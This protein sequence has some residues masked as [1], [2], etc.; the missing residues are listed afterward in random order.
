MVRVWVKVRVKVG[1]GLIRVQRTPEHRA[2]PC[3]SSR[4]SLPRAARRRRPHS[5]PGRHHHRRLAHR[6]KPC[7][8]RCLCAPPA[9]W[10]GAAES[11]DALTTSMERTAARL[12][13]AAWQGWLLPVSPWHIPRHLPLPRPAA[14]VGQLLVPQTRR[15]VGSRPHRHRTCNR[16]WWGLQPY[17]WWGLQPYVCWGH[18]VPLEQRSRLVRAE[19]K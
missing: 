17:V 19:S 16:V 5:R 14:C 10:I 12:V 6:R 3:K 1:I 2:V 18:Y 4:V 11:S 13:W 7:R 8:C 9:A 15:A